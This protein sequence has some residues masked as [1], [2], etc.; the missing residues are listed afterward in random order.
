V[1]NIQ[2]GETANLTVF[3]PEKERVVDIQAFKSKSKNSP[4]HGRRLKGK[5]IGIIN[6]GKSW[7]V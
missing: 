5:T 1:I 2:E 3:D 7:F 6:N 4:F